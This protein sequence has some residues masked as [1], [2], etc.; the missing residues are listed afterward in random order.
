MTE[1]S[2]RALLV[3][4]NISQWTA[5][6]LDRK[7]SAAV[8][9]KHGTAVDAARVNKSLL[10]LNTELDRVH[11]MTSAIRNEYYQLSLP[12]MEGMQIIKSEGYLTF[13]Q[14]M[15]DRKREWNQAVDRFLRSYET[16]VDDAKHLLGTLFN[17]SDYPSVD[18]IRS[19]FNMDVGFYPMP[20]AKD[21]RVDMA[22]DQM[23]SLRKQLEMDVTDKVSQAMQ[24]AWQRV[25]DVVKRIHTQT[26]N[27]EGRIYD[28]L[29]GSAKDLCAILPSLNISDDPK[30]EEVRQE[31][32]GYFATTDAEDIRKHPEVRQ[33][34]SDQ[35]ADILA[36]MGGL[37]GA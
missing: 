7:E 5:R 34:V 16:S 6:K 21:W 24:A 37:Y 35:M 13:A 14:R 28:S 1:L 10:P 27:P 4:L 30:L 12:W 18:T 22:D 26:S 19:K 20:A 8:N 11:K 9:A 25:H 15:A 3:T 2:N 23:D 29:V 36:K 33:E 32:E 17:E 31:L